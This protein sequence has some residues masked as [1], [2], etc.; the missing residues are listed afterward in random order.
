[1]KKGLLLVVSMVLV[2]TLGFAQEVKQKWE[3][4]QL[5]SKL[6][7]KSI[8]GEKGII[9]GYISQTGKYVTIRTKIDGKKS[10]K[11]GK[12]QRNGCFDWK[13][14]GE[15]CNMTLA[16]LQNGKY[17]FQENN[18]AVTP[19]FMLDSGRKYDFKYEY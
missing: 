8:T 14:S 17:V 18:Q 1:M 3:G 2:S 15:Q 19:E 6:I 5:Y 13:K 4:K 12:L 16:L 7:D 11:K 9:L 10:K